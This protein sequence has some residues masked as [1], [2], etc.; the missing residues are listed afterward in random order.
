LCNPRIEATANVHVDDL[1]T[2]S[3]RLLPGLLHGL[4]GA[5]H[6]DGVLRASPGKLDAHGDL[7]VKDLQLEGLSPGAATAAFRANDERITFSKLHVA[8]GKG[9]VLGQ[10][11]ID[12]AARRPALTAEA[13]LR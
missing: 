12:L 6:V 9:E 11:E 10:V 1:E 7:R 8:I 13:T 4:K 5:L 2:A 3:A